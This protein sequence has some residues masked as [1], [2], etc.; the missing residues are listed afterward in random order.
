MNVMGDKI[1]SFVANFVKEL[2]SIFF[3]ISK[4]DKPKKWSIMSHVQKYLLQTKYSYFVS[5][6]TRKYRV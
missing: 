3:C 5:V 1:V 4:F 6:N 2:T